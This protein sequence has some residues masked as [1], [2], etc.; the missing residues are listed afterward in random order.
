MARKRSPKKRP[1][2]VRP[3]RVVMDLFKEKG[4]D[5]IHIR[6]PLQGRAF[7]GVLIDTAEPV[8]PR[9]IPMRDV[10]RECYFKWLRREDG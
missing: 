5:V 4:E 8:D 7:C 3:K 10:C 9:T 6:G 1:E 2:E